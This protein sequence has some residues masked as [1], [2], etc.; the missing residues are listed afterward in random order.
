[1]TRD[2][3]AIDNDGDPYDWDQDGYPNGQE[4]LYGTDILDPIHIQDCL[5]LH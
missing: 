5:T 1:M 2:Y 3:E 4:S